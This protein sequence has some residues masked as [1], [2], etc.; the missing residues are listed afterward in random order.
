M[1]F[2]EK[3]YFYTKIAFFH[4]VEKDEFSTGQRCPSTKKSLE[5]PRFSQ[6]STEF[7]TGKNFQPVENSFCAIFMILDKKEGPEALGSL[8]QKGKKGDFLLWERR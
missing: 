7:S 1:K 8:F 6:E 3:K 5:K 2:F 4:F